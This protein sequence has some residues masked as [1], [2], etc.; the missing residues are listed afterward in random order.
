MQTQANFEEFQRDFPEKL[1]EEA[2]VEGFH[3]LKLR[4]IGLQFKNATGRRVACV[5]ILK[6]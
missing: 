5:T 3:Y 1:P 2:R 6:K 4:K